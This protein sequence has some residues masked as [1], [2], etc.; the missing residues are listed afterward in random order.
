MH[1]DI[2]RVV[3]RTSAASGMG[4]FVIIVYNFRSLSFL[5]QNSVLDVLEVLDLPL[6]TSGLLMTSNKQIFCGL[7]KYNIISLENGCKVE[8][9]WENLS[10]Y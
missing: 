2:A 4:F 3:S 1:I 7:L 8:T 6:I 10:L 9:S 5:I